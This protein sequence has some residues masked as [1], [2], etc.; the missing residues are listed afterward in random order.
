LLRKIEEI[1]DKFATQEGRELYYKASKV[2]QIMTKNMLKQKLKESEAPRI[3]KENENL[4]EM[5]SSKE[6]E[7]SSHS[8]LR[9]REMGMQ[10]VL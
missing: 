7:S 8:S 9:N 6:D 5:N 3:K 1:D 10:I 4:I 2:S